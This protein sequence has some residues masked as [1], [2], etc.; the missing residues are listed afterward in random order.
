MEFNGSK[1]YILSRF[2]NM[3]SISQQQRYLVLQLPIFVK[4]KTQL[5]FKVISID[6]SSIHLFMKINVRMSF[7]L[8]FSIIMCVNCYC[9]LT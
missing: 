5:P 7:I 9:V 2:K 1:I 3:P 6:M 4:S 8:I